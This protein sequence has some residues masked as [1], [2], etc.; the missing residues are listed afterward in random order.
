V[1]G[2]RALEQIAGIARRE[3][4]GVVVMVALWLPLLLVLGSFVIDVGN[5][6]EHRRNLQMQADAAALAAAGE[7]RRPCVN[8]P[9][10]DMAH[11]YGGASPAGAVTGAYNEQV[12]DRPAAN[13]RLLVNSQTW[14]NQPDNVDATVD[15]RE[16]C[17]A[18]MIDVKLTETDL[19]WFLRVARV[20][21][22]INAHARV[23]FRRVGQ[24]PRSSVPIGVPEANPKRG[25]VE[26]VDEGTGEVLGQ[27]PL[28]R[29]DA[30]EGG[31]AI[32]SNAAQPI[33]RRIDRARIGVRVVLSGSDATTFSCGDALV[34]CFEQ[35]SARRGIALIRGYSTQGTVGTTDPPRDRDVRLTSGTCPVTSL[36]TPYFV[37]RDTGCNIGVDAEI[38]F[39]TT[40]P[41]GDRGA[42]VT[43]NLVGDTKKSYAVTYDSERRRW[44]N[45]SAI[46]IAAGSGQTPIELRWEQTKGS[47]VIDGSTKTCSTANNN[48]CKG[49]FDAVHRT[50]SA[51]DD[52]SGPIR[53]VLV[54]E[55]D[56][57][58]VPLPAPANSPYSFPRCTSDTD[59]CSRRL[60][61]DVRIPSLEKAQSADAEPI[62]MRVAGSGS[63]TQALDCDPDVPNLKQELEEG[64]G[65]QYV[66]NTGQSC[67]E[68]L[69]GVDQPWNCVAVST[70][71]A[72][73]HMDGLTQRIL[74]GAKTCTKPNRWASYWTDDG[75]LEP[76]PSDPRL[77]QVMV[78]KFGAF[79]GQ[80]QGTVPVLDFAYFYVTGWRAE[81]DHPCTD[82]GDDPAAKGYI[83]GHFVEYIDRLNTGQ[84]DD[85][86]CDFSD[87][88]A[89]N[90]V[91]VLTH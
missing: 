21:P 88:T 6:F 45:T 75:K 85:E 72:V 26:L 12:G 4:G 39:G 91:A 27:A 79:A 3:D 5:W 24:N 31:D 53:D 52:V 15:T 9:V 56:A 23:S 38:D 13:V 51:N 55:V 42:K 44:T 49:S 36:S 58:G 87:D 19:P 1:L 54:T 11:I 70:G 81:K 34:D 57:E 7:F 84:A 69:T 41:V 83:V 90:C 76:D 61:V 37:G 86:P 8:D 47:V 22:F 78:T 62:A 14:F 25:R 77:V 17:Q 63:R 89:G 60:R 2:V 48:P 43:A 82:E 59:S 10:K 80:G 32:W 50:L 16:P 20:V 71:A 73:S 35:P 29:M 64:C 33:E 68:N 74:D 66:R 28:A 40:N 67:P 46:P 65:R 30:G 18:A